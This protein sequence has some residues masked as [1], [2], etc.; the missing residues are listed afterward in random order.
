MISIVVALARN[1][2]IGK[3]GGLPWYYPEDLKY[4]RNLTY[5]H[6]I[7]MGRKTF[8]SIINR[9]GKPLPRRIHL[10]ASR[11]PSF[12]HPEAEK[13]TDL[14]AFLKQD[15]SEEIFVIGGAEI[16]RAA[17]PHADRLYITH[18]AKEYDGDVFFPEIDFSE[19][20]LL[21][22]KTSNEL[23]FSVYERVRKC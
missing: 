21:S 22:S 3:R 12:E 18:I 11:D 17:L 16:Y 23:T 13:I 1:N 14:E 20:R 10:V 6:K 7:L 5:G 2:V 4:F 19:F 15:F 9:N 8:E